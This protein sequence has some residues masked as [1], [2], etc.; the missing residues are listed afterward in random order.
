M[1]LPVCN[2]NYFFLISH[3]RTKNVIKKIDVV[4][5][6]VGNILPTT[7]LGPTEL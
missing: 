7:M 5:L 4:L 2:V 1:K 3:N 6:F